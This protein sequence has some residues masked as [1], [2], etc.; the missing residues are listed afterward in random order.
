MKWLGDT[1]LN[2]NI[3]GRIQAIENQSLILRSS[4]RRQSFSR[5]KTCGTCIRTLSPKTNPAIHQNEET[6]YDHNL[7]YLV[8]FKV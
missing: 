8:R 4:D 5:F 6:R 1:A 3:K 2:E 7:V